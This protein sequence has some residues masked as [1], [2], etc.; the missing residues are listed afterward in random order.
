MIK[1][2]LEVK[3]RAFYNLFLP[4]GDSVAIRVCEHHL[5]NG[6]MSRMDK[7]PLYLKWAGQSDSVSAV[8]TY[9]L[10]FGEMVLQAVVEA[11]WVPGAESLL[12]KNPNRQVFFLVSA[13]PQGELEEILHKLDLTHCFLRIFGAPTRKTDAIQMALAEHGLASCDCLMIGDALVDLEAADANAVPFL[14]RRHSTNAELFSSYSGP[15]IEDF[16][17][18]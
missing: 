3:S 10:S 17:E 16:V 11:P 2:S 13:T 8:D 15:S 12:R 6:G 18:L 5:A 7:M 4:F 9:C 1:E 14:L